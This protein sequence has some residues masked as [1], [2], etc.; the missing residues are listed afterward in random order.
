MLYPI[1]VYI[2]IRVHV[3]DGFITYARTRQRA[4][5][6]KRKGLGRGKAKVK[7]D[8]ACLY[9]ALDLALIMHELGNTLEHGQYRRRVG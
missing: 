4:G 6:R 1:Y 9:S 3:V 2:I 8:H 7:L 5:Q